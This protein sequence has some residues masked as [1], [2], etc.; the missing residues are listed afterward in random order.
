VDLR[1][2]APAATAHRAHRAAG[3]G[4]P[5]FLLA[6]VAACSSAGG[7]GGDGP[8]RRASFTAIRFDGRGVSEPIRLSVPDRTRS[9]AVVAHGDDQTLYALAS[10]ETADGVEHV[11]LPDDIDLGAVMRE[12]YFEE[13]I[14]RMPGELLQSIR[15]ATFTLV[16]PE[17]PGQAIPPGEA[18][19]RIATSDPAAGPVDVEVLLPPEDGARTLPVNV[20]A[21]SSRFSFAGP[22]SLPFL[23][24]LN[25]MLGSA[26]IEVAVERVVNLPDSGLSRMPE[27]SRPQEPPTSRSS[28]LALL[29]GAMVPGDALN[30]FIVDELPDGVIGWS[31][32]TPGPPLPD[33]CYSGVVATHAR[34]DHLARVLAHEV[35]HYLGLTHVVDTGRSG[36]SYPDTLDDTEPGRGNLMSGEGVA[37][38]PDQAFVVSR[39]PLLR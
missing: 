29:G 30:L 20:F 11:R 1:G 13:E 35:G 3:A 33:T 34:G 5:A 25:S 9:I 2:V 21:V 38:T 23:P 17:R 18:E 6:L 36:A 8:P 10:F 14:A 27:T 37:I 12:R 4:S 22:D 39:S 32:G 24:A 28:E 19:L 15:L 26:G 16:Y 31:L 7:S